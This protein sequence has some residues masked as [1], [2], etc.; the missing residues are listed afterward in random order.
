MNIGGYKRTGGQKMFASLVILAVCI[1][2][3]LRLPRFWAGEVKIAIAAAALAL[4]VVFL[5]YGHFKGKKKETRKHTLQVIKG[6]MAH[7]PKPR[8]QAHGN[9]LGKGKRHKVQK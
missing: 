7:I 8:K 4:F 5:L 2:M 6:G 1:A 9:A 3:A